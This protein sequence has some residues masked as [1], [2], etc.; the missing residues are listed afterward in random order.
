[1][2]GVGSSESSSVDG[3]DVSLCVEVAR[4]GGDG[5][6]KRARPPEL[7]VVLKPPVRSD[8]PRLDSARA[9]NK[10]LG[11][12]RVS[13]RQ[14]LVHGCGTE[15]QNFAD[16]QHPGVRGDYPVLG[17]LQDPGPIRGA[18]PDGEDFRAEVASQEWKSFQL[19]GQTVHSSAA[20]EAGGRGLQS[21]ER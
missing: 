21:A 8:L 17:V 18:P 13:Q 6:R 14:H 1:M 5:S 19:S 16:R 12:T 2:C 9:R 7:S 20:G 15:N 11:C 10:L 4:E 3:R